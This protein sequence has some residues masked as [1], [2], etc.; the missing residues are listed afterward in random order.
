MLLIGYIDILISLK[1][2]GILE[3]SGE[4]E[5]WCV[6]G[7]VTYACEKASFF[8]HVCHTILL[9]SRCAIM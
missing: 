3:R 9:F 2:F 6:G 7:L 5:F 4:A 1:T 8:V